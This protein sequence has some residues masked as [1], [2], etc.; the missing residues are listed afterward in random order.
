MFARINIFEGQ[1]VNMEEGLSALRTGIF[2]AMQKQKGFKN[3]YLLG[4]SDKNKGYLITFWDSE[5]DLQAWL[6]SEEMAQAVVR[7]QEVLPVGSTPPPFEDYQVLYQ[8]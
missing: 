3:L 7:L 1:Q 2:S 5:A 8:A 4:N 6:S